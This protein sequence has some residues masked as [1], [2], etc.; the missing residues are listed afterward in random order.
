MKQHILRIKRILRINCTRKCA[1]VR[2][3]QSHSKDAEKS[4]PKKPP[5]F[6]EVEGFWNVTCGSRSSLFR[7]VVCA[8]VASCAFR[9]CSC[10]QCVRCG[11]PL[12]QGG[13]SFP[14]QFSELVSR[15]TLMSL[16]FPNGVSNASQNFR[17]TCAAPEE[18]IQGIE[19]GQTK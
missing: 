3:H 16:G 8:C 9:A 18:A 11:N 14:G 6:T 10:W 12:R 15:E 19:P 1:I 4:L 7:G 17:T 5:I 2:M 13:G